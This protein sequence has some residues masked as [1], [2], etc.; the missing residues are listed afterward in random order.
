[1]ARRA[2]PGGRRRGAGRAARAS[3]R[4]ATRTSCPRRSPPPA[5]ARRR[6]SGRRRCATSFG[7]YRAPDRRRRGAP[8]RRPS[9]GSRS[10][11]T[12]ST[13]VCE[14]LGRRPED[15]R[16]QARA[17]TATPTAP[18]RSPCARATSGMEVVYEGIRLTP[19]ADRRV[20]ARQRASTSIGLSILSGSH[21]ELI[22]DVDRGAA[23]GAASTPRSSSAGSSPRPTSP[24]LR[25]AGVAAV[26]TPK[27]FDLTAIMRDIVGAGR[28]A[29]GVAAAPRERAAERRRARRA[30]CA[31]RDL[32]R[33][34][35]PPLNLV[36]NRAPARPRGGRGAAARGLP[37]RARAARRPAH[38]VGVTGP[39][40]RR[41]VVAAVGARGGVARA[42]AARSPCSP[43]TRRRKRSG[44]A[45]LGDRA[46]I[47]V[48]PGRPRRVHPLDRRRRAP[49]RARAR[50][51]RGR[52]GAGGRLRRG[53]DRDGRRRPVR[54]RGRRRR[55]HRRRRRAAR[56]AAT[57]CSS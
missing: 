57:R 2:R 38:V 25:E 43:S 20:G 47:D 17:S 52:P 56:V 40:G 44:G 35:R 28:R 27:D 6:A 10:C 23:R 1:M 37:R 31:T 53:G 4:R 14:A 55:R 7:D 32:T 45:L 33:R 26:Y 9:D 5:P 34:A 21:R 54:D 12:R 41:Q 39:P 13:R 16:R 30:G 15:P 22:P 24:P 50:H 11:A 29:H 42:R 51:A 36:E 19:V 18:S 8:R 46:R 3:P 49:R 48:R